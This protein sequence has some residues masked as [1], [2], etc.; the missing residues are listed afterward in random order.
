MDDEVS[1]GPHQGPELSVPGMAVLK[2]GY[3]EAG[4]IVKPEQGTP[5]GGNLSP[6][7]SNVY[8]HY[9]LDLWFEKRF[10]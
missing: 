5:Q 4:K 1:G 7:L 9:V 2:A 10:K 6:I 8:L 3:M